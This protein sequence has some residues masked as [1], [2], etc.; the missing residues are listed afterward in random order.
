MREEVLVEAQE[1]SKE[2]GKSCMSPL[3]M[4]R[5]YVRKLVT[6][7]GIIR[8]FGSVSSILIYILLTSPCHNN[9]TNNSN[10]NYLIYCY[11]MYFSKLT[12]CGR[13]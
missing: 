9:D 6:L 7:K 3:F 10:N 13:M 8:L 1:L 4:L 11:A 12:N 5:T 2:V